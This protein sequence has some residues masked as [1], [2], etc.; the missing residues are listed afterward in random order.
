M[1]PVLAEGAKRASLAHVNVA[2]HNT[3]TSSK[4]PPQKSK[5]A[6]QTKKTRN[7]PQEARETRTSP[8]LSVNNIHNPTE[9]ITPRDLRQSLSTPVDVDGNQDQDDMS[10]NPTQV[11]NKQK[12]NDDDS[13]SYRETPPPPMLPPFPEDEVPQLNSPTVAPVADVE[14]ISSFD[15]DDELSDSSR[16]DYTF[17]NVDLD[18]EGAVSDFSFVDRL[19][20]FLRGEKISPENRA[21][22]EL[23]ILCQAGADTYDRGLTDSNGREDAILQAYKSLLDEID[24]VAFSSPSFK[25]EM[26]VRLKGAQ[27]PLNGASLWLKYKAAR[28]ELRKLHSTFPDDFSKMPSGKNMW[29]L[30]DQHIISLFRH[31][32]VSSY[33]LT[34]DIEFGLFSRIICHL[35]HALYRHQIT[36]MKMMKWSL[37]RFPTHGG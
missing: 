36:M 26:S 34:F 7:T 14:N 35:Y 28:L 6:S 19:I 29:D 10:E 3:A 23:A 5:S 12:E 30:Y 17:G 37:L 18:T 27:K 2:P 11:Q 24:V 1:D 4:H 8:R 33:F 31:A 9:D 20:Q 13:S 21:S 15:P 25:E 22:V 16:R 32:R